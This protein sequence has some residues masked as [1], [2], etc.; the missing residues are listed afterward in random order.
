MSHYA[1][2]SDIEELYGPELLIRLT[3]TS[4]PRT[5]VANADVVDK[6]L[7][8][9][10]DVINA[11]LS[12]EYTVPVSP[13]PGAV[14]TCAIDIAVYRIEDHRIAEAWAEWDNLAGLRQL[15][16]AGAAY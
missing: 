8:G 10:D 4:T 2:Q 1:Q 14:R 13:V 9:A 12:A 15:G 16:H 3:D 6:A 7:L 5:G 11:Y